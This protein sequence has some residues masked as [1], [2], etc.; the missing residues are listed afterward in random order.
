MN[1]RE[2][3]VIVFSILAAIPAA[4]AQSPAP[5]ASPS[6][7]AV[8]PSQEGT[9]P[10]TRAN[11]HAAM[12]ADARLCLEFPTNFQVILCAEKY[13]PHKRNA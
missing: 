7:S 13:L 2:T 6:A 1:R 8:A 9:K 11:R 10:P 5:D 3:T 12:D 4:V